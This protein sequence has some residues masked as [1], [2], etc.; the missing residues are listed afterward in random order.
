MSQL[1][2]MYRI[3][4]ILTSEKFEKDR[5][6]PE[7]MDAWALAALLSFPWRAWTSLVN[8]LAAIFFGAVWLTFCLIAG[9][10]VSRHRQH[11]PD[12]L[13]ISPDVVP[14]TAE[15]PAQPIQVSR[16]A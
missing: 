12:P 5:A 4:N 13:P 10:S 8:V 3:E 6:S 14:L 1:V 9:K 2:P 11:L 7:I 15:Q 16:A